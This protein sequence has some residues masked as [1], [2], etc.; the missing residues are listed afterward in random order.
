M[1]P[2]SPPAPTMSPGWS[3]NGS[4][5]SIASSVDDSKNTVVPDVKSERRTRAPLRPVFLLRLVN[6]LPRDVVVV[7]DERR[8]MRHVRVVRPGL[9]HPVQEPRLRPRR[10]RDQDLTAGEQDG[11]ACLVEFLVVDLERVVAEERALI[12]REVEEPSATRS[13]TASGGNAALE[14]DPLAVRTSERERLG[15][16]RHEHCAQL[17]LALDGAKRVREHLVSHVGARRNDH[18]YRLD[19]RW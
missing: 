10:G 14:G 4:G 2:K 16:R 6:D 18:R 15:L 8:R 5:V 13:R 11:S 7:H 19:A 17:R 12:E 3:A 1:K 9:P